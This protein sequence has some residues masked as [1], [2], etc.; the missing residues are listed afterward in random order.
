MIIPLLVMFLS[1]FCA[2]AQEKMLHKQAERVLGPLTQNFSESSII[3]ER[4]WQELQLD[5][6]IDR[7][8]RTKTSFGKWGLTQLLYPIADKQELLQRQ[9]IIQF[10]VEHED[11][12]LLFQE[13]LALIHRLERSVLAYWDKHDWLN[14]NILQFYYT[15]PA[16]KE[17]NKNS[18][19]LDVGVVTEMLSAWKYLLGALALTGLSKE[20]TQWVYSEKAD[21]DVIGGI[22]EGLQGPISQ[23]SPYKFQLKDVQ[24]PYTQKDYVRAF[25]FQGSWG[26]RYAI[27]QPRV[28][29]I[30][31]LITA[32]LPTLFFDYQWST[33]IYSAGLRIIS[34]YRTLN[35]LQ[36][37]VSDVAHCVKAIKKIQTSIIAQC[38]ECAD[39]FAYDHGYDDEKV[40]I[41]TLLSKK[42]LHKS[43]HLYSRGNVLAMHLKIS[44]KKNR[45]IPLLES[46]AL[47]DAYCSI[48]Q[49]YKEFNEK[50]VVFCFPEFI[51]SA[52]PFLSYHNA[53]LPL[54]APEKAI[55]NDLI[56]GEKSIPEKIIITGPSGGGKSTIL[57]AYGIAAVLAQSWGIVAAQE[58]QQTILSA[59]R[60]SLA[61]VE[62]L[63]KELSTFM[64]EQKIMSDLRDDIRYAEPHEKLLV[65][66]DEPYKGIVEAESARRIYQF[67]KD[68]ASADQALVVI[69]THVRKPIMLEKDTNGVFGNY[70]VKIK[71]TAPGMFKRLFKLQRG[72]ALW[73]L[74]DEDKRGRFVDWLGMS[75]NADE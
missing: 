72:P 74:D 71:E 33:T 11:I 68:I 5:R 46:I 1:S 24:P 10:L 43:E 65:L 67:G 54:L 56:L 60:T 26:D 3:T 70:Q 6:L 40:F 28:G 51:E 9:S 75:A 49:L 36:R 30:G 25:A 62:N 21:V 19:A 66:I 63:N 23:H 22:R 73:W 59:I 42:N 35:M 15:F 8:D 13:Q 53:W 50:E 64:A 44:Q 16:F 32:T 41:D 17:F 57:K 48:A 4:E 69:A 38:P 7:L 31:A 52:Q 58:C 37:R 29:M 47:L 61:S 39:Y 14:Q 55:I 20:I 18:L 27:M 12:M 2:I 34:M 45:L